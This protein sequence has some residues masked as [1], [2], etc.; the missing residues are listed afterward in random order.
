MSS[1]GALGTGAGGHAPP[2]N[3]RTTRSN[4][5]A[6]MQQPSATAQLATAEKK[7]TK[8]REAE[9]EARKTLSEE[10]CLNAEEALTLQNI[11][12]TLTLL[13]RKYNSNAPTSLLKA[14]K[15]V[16]TLAAR[17]ENANGQFEPVVDAITQRLGEHFEK[18]LHTEMDKL[19]TVITSS[20]AEQTRSLNT[21]GALTETITNLKQV[22]SDM[23]KT[24][25]EATT[26]TTHIN[27]TAL[28]YKQALLHTTA[29][30][31]PPPPQTQQVRPHNDI[32]YDNTAILL[33]IDKKARQILFDSGKGEDNLWN[34]SEIREKAKA[35]MANIQPAPP[36]DTEIQEVIK[37]RK[38][39]LI[40]Q[41][42]TKEAAD[43]LRKP[44]VATAFTKKFDPDTAIRDR[45]HPIMVPR[46]P[47][48][49][50]PGNPAHLREVEETNGL[51]PKT[52]K[53]ARWIKPEY[54]RAPGQ[55]CAHAIFTISSVTNANRAIK[56]GIYICNT[57]TFPK[58]LKFEPKQCMKCRKWG[59]YA[60]EC[61]AEKDACGTCGG[62]HKMNECKI[63][64][65][66]YCVSCRSDTHASW[67]RKCPEFIR[68]CDEYSGFH[69][70]NNLVYF[71]TDEDWTVTTR[72]YKVPF[73]DKFPAR[74][75][76]CS[77]PLPNQKARLPPTRPIGKKNK[78]R[79][80]NNGPGQAVIE[81]FFTNENA[82]MLTEPGELPEVHGDDSEDEY[83]TQLD[84]AIGTLSANFLQNLKP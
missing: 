4:T 84:H 42:V 45:T 14:I 58:K 54:R 38:G 52:I 3:L 2:A 28:N 15:A 16:A 6:N 78:K 12:H 34:T 77:L 20:L 10:E 74:F 81:N 30:P 62:Q 55:S 27:N 31:P 9:E 17:I 18:S 71:P 32:R 39:S 36:E 56:E 19:S 13:V 49:F 35:A 68:K 61:R 25:N 33:G 53:K 21:P 48:T 57:C 63:E 26:A 51:T 22:A 66:R 1:K 65:K 47:L 8:A 67:D 83:D 60:S 7:K 41:F 80:N 73:E 46:I 75:N 44:E 72:P 23:S 64:N 37:L 76:V 70:E 59:H 43:W 50:D 5:K 69:P 11:P 82:D 40:L 24:I 79:N 29:K